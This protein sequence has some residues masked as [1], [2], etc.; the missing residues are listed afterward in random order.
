MHLKKFM[1]TFG[2]ILICT[3]VALY[4][5][6]FSS[7][8]VEKDLR[9]QYLKG[10][11]FQLKHDGKAFQLSQLKGSPVILYFGF[12]HCPDVC[13]VGLAVIRDALNSSTSLADVPVV[14]VTLDPDRDT[15][16]ILKQYTSFFHSNIIPLRGTL[17]ET[18]S[19]IESYGGFFRLNKSQAD[20]A[21]EANYSVDHS[22]YY[23]LIDS[24][25]ELMRVLDH[26]AS[27]TEI[28]DTLKSLL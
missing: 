27:S 5:V 15:P 19:V 7:P 21:S 1:F 22:A 6:I 26:S 16:E 17:E 8:K 9:S 20:S 18:K 3:C 2:S 14:F 11:D 10:G 23:Y 12:T 4:L 13:P 25:G 28:A 24:S